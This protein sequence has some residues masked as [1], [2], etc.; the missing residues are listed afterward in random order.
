MIK[1]MRH[2]NLLARAGIVG[3]ASFIEGLDSSVR[4]VYHVLLPD[5]GGDAVLR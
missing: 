2:E 5:R 1:K 3:R 4:L